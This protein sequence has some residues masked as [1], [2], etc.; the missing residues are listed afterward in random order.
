MDAYTD[1]SPPQ[2][3]N[4]HEPFFKYISLILGGGGGGA[5]APQ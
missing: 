2:E 5:I 3:V 1:K 4:K